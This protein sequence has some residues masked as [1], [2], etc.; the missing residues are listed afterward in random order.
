M[1][2]NIGSIFPVIDFVL[3][4]PGG[5][6]N[7]DDT[8][9]IGKCYLSISNEDIVQQ[10]GKREARGDSFCVIMLTTDFGSSQTIK[11]TRRLGYM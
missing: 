9:G 7:D 2:F 1:V 11:Y 3:A 6:L 8:A 5:V 4:G 10:L